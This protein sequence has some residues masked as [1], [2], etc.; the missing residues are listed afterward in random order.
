MEKPMNSFQ[1]TYFLFCVK[2]EKYLTELIQYKYHNNDLI[3]ETNCKL[4][5]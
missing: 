2:P 4:I 1:R 5:T 3:D